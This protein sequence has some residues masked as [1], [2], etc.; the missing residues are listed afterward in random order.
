MNPGK[1]L[2]MRR[3]LSACP[4][5]LLFAGCTSMYQ[6]RGT[7]AI[8]PPGARVTLDDF[9][10][11]DV[12]SADPVK[13]AQQLNFEHQST[14]YFDGFTVG[15]I[16]IGDDGLINRTQYQQVTDMLDTQTK[17][18]GLIVVFVHGWHHGPRTCDRDL[19]CFRRVLNRL[20][21]SGIRNVVGLYIGWRG[22][23]VAASGA[24]MLTLADRKKVAER[25]GRTAGKE[26][27]LD[28][29]ERW[30]HNP[31]LHMVTVGHSL[32]GAF[33]FKA[34]KGKLTGSIGDIT[35]T[36]SSYR[37][38]RT[39]C[40][41]VAGSRY[42]AQRARLGDLVVLVNPA[43][44]ASEW[45]PFDKDLKDNHAPTLRGELIAERQPYDK[46]AVYDPKQ[47]PVLITIASSADTAVSRLFPIFRG[48]TG[49]FSGPEARGM[50][51]F[52]PHITHDL[53]SAIEPI[54]RD[55]VAKRAPRKRTEVGCDCTMLS[56][57][58]AESPEEPKEAETSPEAKP[59]SAYGAMKRAI[60]P[61]YRL[62]LT[63]ERKARGW[64]ENSP[65]YVIRTKKK[66]IAE[67]S[68]IFNPQFVGFLVNFIN[69]FKKP[70]VQ[71]EVPSLQTVSK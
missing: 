17:D 43:I 47:L 21:R 14:E 16:E 25:I 19:C 40:A 30:L 65:Y 10:G 36:P 69:G 11:Q 64:D 56:E 27:L 28:L 22:E 18:G 71:C 37:V 26:I 38:A 59:E 24:S 49:R 7:E 68:D 9:A 15:V 34:A 50:G 8:T 67:H 41:R 57:E 52:T 53:S 35:G 3:I 61:A 13:L 20:A 33:V 1:E 44:E 46:A 51:H 58:P 29:N 31:N 39:Q 4:I 42:K 60:G 6:V 63:P 55:E 45:I 48:L 62:E 5:F 23:S 12:E 70:A 66:I 54:D 2:V 32:G